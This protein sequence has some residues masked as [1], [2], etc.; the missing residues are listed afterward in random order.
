MRASGILLP[1]ASLPSNYGIGCFSKSAYDFIDTLKK[2]GQSYWQML[3]IGPTGFGDSPYQSF[4]TFAGNP[5][6]IDLDALIEEGLLQKRECDSYD[7]GDDIRYID[8]E[9]IYL[10]RFKLLRIAYERSNIGNKKEFKEFNG[11]NAYWL[12]D[13]ALYMAVKKHFNGVSWSKWNQDIKLRKSEAMKYYQKE[14]AIEIEFY[15]Y[16]QYVFT[17]QWRKLKKYAN[18][19]GIQI[20][21]DIPIYVAFDSADTW[22]NPELFH[23]DKFKNPIAVAGCPPD[24]FASEGQLWG[25]PLYRWDYHKEHNFDWWLKRISYCFELYDVLRVDHFKG[26]DEYYSIPFGDTTAEFGHWEKGPGIEFFQKVKSQFGEINIIAEDL[27]NITDSV[28]MLLKQTG[29]PGMKV[30]QFAFDSREESD[31]LPH[32]YEKNSIVYTGTHDNDTIGGWYE[33]LCK[34]DLELSKSYMNNYNT[35]K[36]EIHWDFIRLAQ[37]SVSKLCIIPIQ[38]Y[39]GLDSKARINTP[40]TVG[41]NW[42]WRLVNGDISE[43][44]IKR[45]YNIT[46]LYGRLSG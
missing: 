10:S 28:R 13:Y 23:L 44:L 29:Y 35:D 21:G 11:I 16:I 14:L 31:Y 39:L 37:Q 38:D 25:N 7:I 4:S 12:D 46:K 26:F 1:I 19:K 40:S 5:Y 3:P 9:K 17:N 32:N 36:K 2:A 8:Y 42:K 43:D 6:F 20:I 22:S 34:E 18:E 30:L 45:V 41:D 24:A 33:Q 15:K 27:G